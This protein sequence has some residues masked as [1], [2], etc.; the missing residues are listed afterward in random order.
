MADRTD[1]RTAHAGLHWRHGWRRWVVEDYNA[2]RSI[3]V[4]EDK[5]VKAAEAM[6][7]LE[8]LFAALRSDS[9]ELRYFC[10]LGS[11]TV[12]ARTCRGNGRRFAG[13]MKSRD[14][15]RWTTFIARQAGSAPTSCRMLLVARP[16]QAHYLGNQRRLDFP[17][18]LPRTVGCGGSGSLWLAGRGGVCRVSAVSLGKVVFSNFQSRSARGDGMPVTIPR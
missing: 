7:T 5:V 9:A 12:A 1:R 8:G 10:S 13:L 18:L 2:L 17:C 4:A 14:S 3:G 11:V 15:H 6:A 16:L